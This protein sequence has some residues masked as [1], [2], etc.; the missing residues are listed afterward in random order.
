MTQPDNAVRRILFVNEANEK[1]L[2]ELISYFVAK[3]KPV[4]FIGAGVSARP[5]IRPGACRLMHC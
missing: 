5:A 2:K 3:E 4:A 1:G